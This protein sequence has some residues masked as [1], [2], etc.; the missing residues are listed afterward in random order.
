[1]SDWKNVQSRSVECRVVGFQGFS[2]NSTTANIKLARWLIMSESLDLISLILGVT[3]TAAIGV[4]AFLIKTAI[5]FQREKKRIDY[6]K[7]L[8]NRTRA[9]LIARLFAEWLS[10]PPGASMLPDQRKRL[11]ALSFE[12]TLW[13]PEK[14][15]LEL[16]KVLQAAPDAKNTFDILLN[17]R[18]YLS[19]PHSL[20]VA[21][22]THWNCQHELSKQTL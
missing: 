22:V 13:L 11:N 21:H 16:S 4:L 8:E 1:M 6:E 18:E 5:S 7:E 15:A 9:Q 10:A 12:A 19:G 17:V 20:T 2:S 14:I 3:T